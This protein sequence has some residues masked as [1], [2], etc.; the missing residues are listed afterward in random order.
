VDTPLK[1]MRGFGEGRDLRGRRALRIVGWLAAAVAAVVLLV[2]AASF[3]PIGDPDTASHPN[4]ARS[5]DEAVARIRAQQAQEAKLPLQPITHSVALVHPSVVETAVVIF[6][7]YTHSP[8]QWRV[9][10]KA[11]YDQGYN[12]WIPVMPFHG[13]TD[14]MTDAPSGLTAE[15]TREFADRAI[16]IGA[17][18]GKHVEVVGL[19]NGGVLAAW[20]AA[21]RKDVSRTIAVAPVFAPAGVPDW[22][23]MPLVRLVRWL[24]FDLYN[25]WDQNTRENNPG[26]A[27]PRFSFKGLA[28]L[29]DVGHR[30]IIDEATGSRPA[31]GTVELVAN[32]GDGQVNVPYNISI[33]K[34]IGPP[35]RVTIFAIPA[36]E[37]FGHDIVEPDGQNK[38]V[39]RKVYPV[40]AKALGISLPDPT[41]PGSELTTYSILPDVP[42]K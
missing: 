9:V 42:A 7:G 37:G 19:S 14:R 41:L 15:V 3:L 36:S 11:L 24:P 10:S 26:P 18:L 28:A 33:I 31:S 39:I 1:E 17:G 25:W 16:D 30:V 2:L 35:D 27:Y 20:A 6:H 29:V 13:Y 32:W 8:Y 4:P 38:A 21:E 34:A 40:L 22:A 12:V 23:T 5:F